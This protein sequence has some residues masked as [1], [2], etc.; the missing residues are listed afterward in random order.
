MEPSSLSVCR[1]VIL[2]IDRFTKSIHRLWHGFWTVFVLLSLF[3]GARIGEASKPGPVSNGPCWSLGVVNP[4]G[5]L[6]KSH[7]LGTVPNDVIAVSETHLTKVSK[8][9][10]F[11]SLKSSGAGFSHFVSGSPMN[12]RSD[13]SDAGDWAG[14]AVTSKFPSRAMAVTWPDDLFE[15]GRIMFCAT[16][17]VSFWLCGGVIYGIPPGITHPNAWERTMDML[18]FAVDYMIHSCVGPRYLAGDW[19]FEPHQIRCWQTLQSAGWIEVQD[20]WEQHSGSPPTKTCKSKTRK[21]YLWLSPELARHF[22]SL[23]FHDTFADHLV[24]SATFGNRQEV[25]DRWLWPKPSPIDWTSVPDLPS[26]VDF[27]SGDPSDLYQALWNTREQQAQLSLD[28]KWN[29][30][31]AGR[32]SIR[33]PLYRQ[34]WPAPLK[35]GRS[36]DIQ[37]GFHGVSVLHSRWFK[38]L[39]RLQSYVRWASSQHTSAERGVHGALLW[40]SILQ[41]SGFRPSFAD[42]WQSRAYRSP[43]DVCEVP[44]FP[45][46]TRIA[47]GIFEAL[48]AEVR[49]LENNLTQARRSVAQFRRTQEPQTI[50]QDVR[51]PAA[52]PVETLLE[53]RASVVAR[54]DEQDQAI[55]LDPPTTFAEGIPILASGHPITIHHA[56][57]DKLWVEKL[58]PVKPGDKIVQTKLIGSLP[59]IFAAF[60]VQWKRRWC[61]HD[62]V[63][64]SQWEDIINFARQVM[65]YRPPEPFVLSPDLLKAE[66]HR[67]KKTAATGLDGASRADFIGGGPLFLQSLLSLYDRACTDGCWPTQILS[68]SVASLAK[69]PDAATVNQYRPITIFGFAY[70]CWASLHARVLLDAADSWADPGIFGNRKGHQAAHL[71]KELVHQLE[72]AYST[73]SVL[74]GL[75]ADIEKAYNCLPRWPIFCAALFGGTPFPVLTGWVGAVTNMRRHFKVQDS[76]SEG[77]DTS[78]GLAEGCALSCYGM[79]VLDHLFHTWLRFECPSVQAYSYVDNWDLVTHDPNYAVH[80][81][82]LVLDFAAKV[83]LTIDKGKTYGWSTCPNIRRQFRESQIPVKGAAKDLGAHIS[84]NKQYTNSTVKDRLDSLDDFWNSLKRSPSPYRVKIQTVRTVAWPRG[85]HAVSSTPIGTTVWGQLRSAV[86]QATLGRKAGVNPFVLLCLVEGSVDPEEV[87]LISSM[88]D[89]REFSPEGHMVSTMAPLAQGSLDLPPNAPSA[90]FLTRLHRVGISVLDNG[91]L[92]DRFGTFNLHDSFQEVL[93]RLQ[94]ACQ[95]QAASAVAHRDDFQGLSW[96]NVWSTRQKLQSLTPALQALYRLNLAGGSFTADFS[97]HW[98]DSGSSEC[99]WCG[100]PDSLNHRFWLC[101]QTAPLRLKHAPVASQYADTLPSALALRGWALY[102][103]TWPL[104]I[105]YLANLPHE[106]PQPFH[107]FP[108]L[109][110]VD[111]FTDGSCFWQA[112]PSLRLAAWSAVIALPFDASWRFDVHGL[113]GASYLPGV[114]QSAYRAELYALGFV[115]H[116]ASV[117]HTPVRVWSDCLGVVNRFLL[118]CCGKRQVRPNTVNSDLWTWVMQSVHELGKQNIKIFKVPAHQDVRR[119]TSLKQAWL[120]WNNGAADRAARMANNN[121]PSSCWNLWTKFASEFLWAQNIHSEVVAL[122]LAVA[123]MSIRTAPTDPLEI[124]NRPRRSHRIFHRFYDG[125]GW[126]GSSLSLMAQRYNNNLATK[127]SRWWKT[128]VVADSTALVWVPLVYLYIDF[129]LT[130]GCPGPMKVQKKWVESC[131]RP[132]LLPE[133]YKH[134]QRLRWFRTFLSYFW[135]TVG[136]SL[137]SATCRPDTEVIQAFVPAFSLAWDPWCLAQVENWLRSHLVKPCARAALELRNIPLARTNTAMALSLLPT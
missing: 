8:N 15:S 58:P 60:H 46:S 95:Q 125:A 75:T 100:A 99:K 26:V 135:K 2:M 121:R 48:Q 87:A 79:L 47:Q 28:T 134:S 130:Y 97:F 24:M 136:I 23:D 50:Y 3:G 5:L 20:L 115:L 4:S 83:D 64:L 54:I 82:Q 39:R 25:A 106:I 61:R 63:P 55:E 86:V 69:T 66:I 123:E 31:M 114:V 30:N 6:G 53:N 41:A 113:L 19:N 81:L 109:P 89:A 18:D 120:I 91:D 36:Q 17:L 27:H 101:P 72:T 107:V 110:W 32:A 103:P 92:Q 62:A 118:L 1:F 131:Q 76:F 51:R 49:V 122:H 93:L 77:F 71:W 128:R 105:S 21:D 7:I 127:V 45:P 94:W 12:P 34:G 117:S 85:L 42:W 90:V 104:W 98:T 57:P 112:Q 111:V 70:R 108:A 133:R 38:Q 68:G 124:E 33:A 9:S 16:Y 78:T 132:Y 29:P 14:V 80:Q 137:G 40:T 88:R 65:P 22:L 43:S 102:T 11:C 119:A 74:S 116:W 129:Q 56:E 35:K 84:Y 73:G 59:D 96:V 126:E 52:L 13:V 10:F 44:A 37:P 67:K